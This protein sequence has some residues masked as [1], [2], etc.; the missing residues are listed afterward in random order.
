MT[1][2]KG[3]LNGVKKEMKRVKWP[4]KKYMF[5]SSVA[6]I[7]FGLIFSV[8]FYLLDLMMAFVRSRLG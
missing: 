1:K 6:V 4:D 7:S 5:K 2:I 3:F 8:Y